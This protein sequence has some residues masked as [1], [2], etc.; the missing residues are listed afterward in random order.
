MFAGAHVYTYMC[1]PR[2][3]VLYDEFDIPIVDQREKTCWIEE[4]FLD[5]DLS[6]P[7][8]RYYIAA[9]NCTT[10]ADESYYLTIHVYSPMLS[11]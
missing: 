11:T 7:Y 6:R 4:P 5:T 2:Q 9:C 10:K 1:T 8:I 3:Q